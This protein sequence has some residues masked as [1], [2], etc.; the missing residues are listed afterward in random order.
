M[1]LLSLC[2][3]HFMIGEFDSICKDDIYFMSKMRHLPDICKY[4]YD[5][6]FNRSNCIDLIDTCWRLRLIKF[7]IIDLQKN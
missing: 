5:R 3:L 4:Q 2:C 6:K 1:L 7:H